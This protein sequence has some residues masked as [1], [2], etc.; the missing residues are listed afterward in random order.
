M[1]Q[2][3]FFNNLQFYCDKKKTFIP[4]GTSQ[5]LADT[6]AKYIK[7]KNQKILDFGCGGGFLLNHLNC[8]NK[9]GVELNDIARNHCIEKFNLVTHKFLKEVPDNSIDV[10]VSNNC[11]EHVPNPDHLIG[12]LYDKLKEGGKIVICVPL[13]S[14]KYKYSADDINF[15]LYSFSPMNLGNLLC[16]N[17]FNVENVKI[18]YHKWPPRPKLL[19]SI[20][21][22]RLFHILSYVYGRIRTNYVQVIGVGV[23]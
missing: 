21:G 6:C 23:K 8:L 1:H 15:H 10:V 16:N 11:L 22:K 3:I 4:T 19:I 12:E 20:F 18:L 5:I 17:N 9:V 7:K 14:R 13:D 2:K